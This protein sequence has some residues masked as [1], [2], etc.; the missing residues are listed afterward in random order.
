MQSMR[1]AKSE[2]KDKIFEQDSI[3]QQ[4]GTKKIEVKNIYRIDCNLRVI[5]QLTERS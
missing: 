2:Q 4:I 3:Q 1:A 5:S